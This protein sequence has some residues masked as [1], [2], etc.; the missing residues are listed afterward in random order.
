MTA[1]PVDKRTD[2]VAPDPRPGWYTPWALLIVGVLLFAATYDANSTPRYLVTVAV[3]SLAALVPPV[4][5]RLATTIDRVRTPSRRQA[6]LT[7]FAVF[8]L[9]GWYF[10]FGATFAGR[11]LFPM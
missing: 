7:F 3:A 9:S 11:N 8:F 6:L 2:A 1:T 5:R 4:R 10:V